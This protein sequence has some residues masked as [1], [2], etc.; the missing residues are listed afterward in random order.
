MELK[1]YPSSSPGFA[2][3]APGGG[4]RRHHF[5]PKAAKRQ[6]GKK[7]SPDQGLHHSIEAMVMGTMQAVL[8]GRW[9]YHVRWKVT[10]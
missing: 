1:G 8:A 7:K 4:I 5:S 2:A 10:M 9:V 6:G 3:Q